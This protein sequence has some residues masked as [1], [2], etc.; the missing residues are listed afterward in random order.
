MNRQR[1]VVMHV[2][3]QDIKQVVPTWALERQDS[4]ERWEDE[5]GKEDD[6]HHL[7]HAASVAGTACLQTAHMASHFTL[8]GCC[9]FPLPVAGSK[10]SMYTDLF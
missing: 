5:I 3:P 7:A 2:E 9:V 4:P 1:R 8:L 6:R 10:Y